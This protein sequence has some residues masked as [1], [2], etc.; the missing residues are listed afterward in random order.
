MDTSRAKIGAVGVFGWGVFL[1]SFF[2][3][4]RYFASLLCLFFI[5]LLYHR[6][7]FFAFPFITTLYTICD[8]S[9]SFFFF[10]LRC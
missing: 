2:L 9:G 8:G 3:V 6:T 10:T 7:F 5:T 4:D 1:L